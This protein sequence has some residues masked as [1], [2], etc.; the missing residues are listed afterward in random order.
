[1]GMDFTAYMS[2]N[3]NETDILELCI[4]LN[5]NSSRFP[6]IREFIDTLLPFNPE[7]IDRKWRITHDSLGGTISLDGPCGISLT[8]SEKVCYFHHYFRWRGFLVDT[9]I[10]QWLRNVSY[11]FMKI[12]NSS[13]VI[14]V[15]D[16]AAKESAI[17]DFIWEDENKDI[18][19]IREWLLKHCG[20]PKDNITDIYKE[21]ED[22]WA[23]EG[24]YIDDFN[25]KQETHKSSNS[26]S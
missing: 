14:Y 21:Y 2:H 13:F 6:F 16:N 26:N 17:M 18:N 4:D 15:P 5:E 9:E 7:D 8:L 25:D 20:I 12:F 22:Y 10:Q 1:M 19:Y 24:Y 23:S 3:L 11:G